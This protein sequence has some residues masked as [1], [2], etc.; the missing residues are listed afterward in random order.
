MKTA[1][2]I[3]K[4][5]ELLHSRG[6]EFPNEKKAKEILLDIGYYRLG[7]YWFPYEK[8]YPA[9]NNRNHKFKENVSFDNVITLYYFDHDLRNIIAPYLY[10][11][12]VNFRTFLTYTVSN[13]YK[14]DPT[15]F[16]DS[17]IVNS[18][19]VD[20]LP[21]SYKT[22]RKNDAIKH[23]HAKYINDIYAPAWKTLE[24]MTFGDVLYLYSSLK[25]PT[26]KETIALH[27]NIKNVEVF[28][29]YMGALRVIRNLCAHGHN[30]YDLKLQK[31]IRKGPIAE[32]EGNRLHN[33]TG[34]L[35]V[36]TY[37]LNSISTNR[38][39]DLR[40]KLNLL[41]SQPQISNIEDV[42]KELKEFIKGG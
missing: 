1:T 42:I 20:Y 2:T 27:Y 38:V 10:R 41:V 22:I 21:G 33:L 23:H 40:Y 28:E 26:L 16:A 24:Y 13:R 31:R 39:Q 19:F 4:Q 18:E 17:R 5:I 9:K 29:S 11:I 36:L 15:W 3:E 30:I 8:T 7:F 12:E 32:L 37:I 34:G 6:M 25:D 14:N 35:L